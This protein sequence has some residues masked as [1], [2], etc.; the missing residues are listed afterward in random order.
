MVQGTTA[1][2][3]AMTSGAIY[4]GLATGSVGSANYLYAADNTEHSNV[5]DTN[6]NNVTSTTFAGRFVDPNALA[7]FNPFNIQDINGNLYVTYAKVNMMGVGQ[8]GGFVDEF[9]SSGD[10]LKRIATSGG[11]Y[12][13]WGITL[14]PSKFGSLAGDLLIGQFGNGQILAYNPTTNAFVGSLI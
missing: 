6:F 14:A 1:V 13:P 3:V 2:N 12:A 8:P 10:F 5:F 4:T 11:L 7:G 9:D